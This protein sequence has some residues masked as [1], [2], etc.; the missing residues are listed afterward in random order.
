MKKYDKTL[1][2]TWIEDIG[3]KLSFTTIKPLHVA[4][5]IQL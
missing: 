2:S 4:L 1:E 3:I 5:T